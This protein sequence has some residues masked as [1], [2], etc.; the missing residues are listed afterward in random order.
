MRALPAAPSPYSGSSAESPDLTPREYVSLQCSGFPGPRRRAHTAK[1]GCSDVLANASPPYS[2]GPPQPHLAG[3]VR[4]P[5]GGAPSGAGCSVPCSTGTP[6]SRQN[7]ASPGSVGA[8]CL[9]DLQREAWSPGAMIVPGVL[10]FGGGER[11][12]MGAHWGVPRVVASERGWGGQRLCL[13][14]PAPTCLE[15][16]CLL[17]CARERTESGAVR[18]PGMTPGSPWLVGEPG[19]LYRRYH[20]EALE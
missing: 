1:S 10:A 15:L 7:G 3:A 14:A 5:A 2:G 18:H 13:G 12:G 17:G 9:G 4:G 16:G 6:A 19:N 20:R 11:T 8:R